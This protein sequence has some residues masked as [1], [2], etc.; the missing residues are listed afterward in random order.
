[1]FKQI[2]IHK[3]R[4]TKRFSESESDRLISLLIIIQ[5]LAKISLSAIAELQ[6]PSTS[7]VQ[8]IID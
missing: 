7:T 4:I 3:V 8:G 2:V 5:L 1:M 6:E